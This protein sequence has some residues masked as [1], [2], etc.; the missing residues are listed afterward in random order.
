MFQARGGVVQVDGAGG[1]FD[2]G[3]A[4]VVVEGMELFQVQDAGHAGDG[5]ARDARGAAVE[6]VGVCVGPAV[7]AGDDGHAI[8][9]Q[10]V[11]GAEVVAVGRD[12]FE[13]G[14]AGDEQKAD[15]M[16]E[17]IRRR[18]IGRGAADEVE[19]GMVFDLA[20]AVV[21]QVGNAADGFRDHA[22]RAIG[23]RV[24][25]EAFAREGCVVA[26]RVDGCARAVDGDE[27]GSAVGFVLGCWRKRTQACARARREG[28]GG[29]EKGHGGT[30]FPLSL[31]TWRGRGCPKGG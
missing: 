12:G 19:Q 13:V 24:L 7:G 11:E 5:V 28:A 21:E 6:R 29:A 30:L 17:K 9:A 2:G 27:G 1:G 8:G 16:L 22:H 25:H 4:V 26:G 10:R 3:E 23:D 15:Q 14:V 18:R 31:A 20:G